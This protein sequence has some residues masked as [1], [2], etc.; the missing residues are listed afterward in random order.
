MSAPDYVDLFTVTT[1]R[2]I[3]HSPERC[4]RI[5]LDG[6]SPVG[7]FV[8]WQLLCHLRLQKEAS[9]D[10][11]A[12]WKIGDR[13]NSWI[14]LE[15]RSWFMTAH[16]VVDVDEDRLSMALFIHYDN[17][18]G[19]LWWPPISAIHRRA[20]PGLLRQAARGIERA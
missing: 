12:G 11:V 20:M 8:A 13:G 10:Y 15:A 18:V 2:P 9:P 7:R 19:R 14:R 16:A 4:A 3:E 5:A 17:P 6:A 1:R